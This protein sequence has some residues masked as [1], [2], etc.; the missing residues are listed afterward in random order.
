MW[1]R[2]T[3]FTCIYKVSNATEITFWGLYQKIFLPCFLQSAGTAIG[4]IPPYYMSRSARLL[5]IEAGMDQHPDT[6]IPEEL[7]EQDKAKLHSIEAIR[8]QKIAEILQ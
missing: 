1:L 7:E 8:D 5:A 4:E 6:A 2:S 3:T